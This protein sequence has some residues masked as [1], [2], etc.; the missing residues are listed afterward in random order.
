MLTSMGLREVSLVAGLGAIFTQALSGAPRA[1][2]YS[3]SIPS[4]NPCSPAVTG[5]IVQSLLMPL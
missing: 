1:G 4:D 3:M 5:D 2:T